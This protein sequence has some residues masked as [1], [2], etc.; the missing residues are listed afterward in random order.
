MAAT[1]TLKLPEELKARIAPL[2][3]SADKTPH[4]W[5]I[6]ALEVQA[7]LSEMRQSF[8]N[9]ALVS[10][11]EIDAGGALYAMQEVHEYLLAKAAGKT[12]KRPKPATA[13][14]N[15]AIKNKPRATK[16]KNRSC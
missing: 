1:T 2:A 10:A 7:R 9:D 14:K 3:E 6:E 11:A 16:T 13:A 15:A 4:A 8:I 12:A 5:M